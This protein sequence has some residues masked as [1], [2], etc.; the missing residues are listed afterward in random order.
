MKKFAIVSTWNG[1]GYSYQSKLRL[2]FNGTETEAKDKTKSL[3]CETEGEKIEIEERENGYT[4]NFSNDENNHGSYQFLELND[5]SYGIVITCNVNE[6]EVLTKEE[7]H[8][9]MEYAILDSKD[10]D[11]SDFNGFTVFISTVDSGEELLFI[12]L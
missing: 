10:L 6:V 8:E 4:F 12:E 2:I 5:D 9:R 3:M 7:F 1:E 11:D